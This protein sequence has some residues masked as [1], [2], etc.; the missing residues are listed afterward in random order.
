MIETQTK[1]IRHYDKVI[2][3]AREITTA[4][5]SEGGSVGA[6]LSARQKAECQRES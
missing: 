2:E 1:L 3:G 5:V 6:G 4:Q